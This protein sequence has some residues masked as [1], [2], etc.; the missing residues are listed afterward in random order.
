MRLTRVSSVDALSQSLSTTGFY[1]MF[2]FPVISFGRH[3]Y[4]ESSILI[5]DPLYV[6]G[7][8]HSGTLRAVA[9]ISVVWEKKVDKIV[10]RGA[11]TKYRYLHGDSM[12][13]RR[14]FIDLVRN[15]SKSKY[16]VSL[17]DLVDADFSLSDDDNDITLQDVEYMGRFK[18]QLEIDGSASSFTSLWLKFA[19]NGLV[20]KVESHLETF[21]SEHWLPWVHFV[22]VKA[23]LSDLQIRLE[24]ARS[25]DRR[26]QEI[27]DAGHHLAMGLNYNGTLAQKW[28]NQ[29]QR[30]T[31]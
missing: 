8:G 31:F 29:C 6:W 4:D 21:F 2:N 26:S 11:D 20:F 13:Q 25:H 19:T 10:W 1:P 16:N 22:P 18:Y 27:A 7:N 9:D 3:R 30:Y 5:P 17:S 24:W 12:G 23:D 14:V 28:H 15:K